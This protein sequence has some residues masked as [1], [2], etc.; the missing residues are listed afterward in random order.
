MEIYLKT[1]IKSKS[2]QH[3]K[4]LQIIITSTKWVYQKIS[5][6]QGTSSKTLFLNHYGEEL[7]RIDRS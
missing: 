5:Q 6:T 3:A 4:S 7:L 1:Y 2:R